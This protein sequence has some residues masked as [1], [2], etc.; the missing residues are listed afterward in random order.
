MIQGVIGGFPSAEYDVG[1]HDDSIGGTSWIE[2]IKLQASRRDTQALYDVVCA[3][4]P[5]R[6]WMGGG[7]RQR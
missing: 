5:I 1:P 6:G 7:G 2:G 4:C 3:I